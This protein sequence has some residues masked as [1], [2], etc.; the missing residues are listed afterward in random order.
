MIKMW[1]ISFLFYVKGDKTNPENITVEIENDPK[2]G[3]LGI[4]E[5]VD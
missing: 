4:H 2:H 1:G 3:N 5:K